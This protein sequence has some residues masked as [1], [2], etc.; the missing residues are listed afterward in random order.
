MLI[1]TIGLILGANVFGHL[2]F[3]HTKAIVPSAITIITTFSPYVKTF[4]TSFVES[5][6]LVISS[7][8]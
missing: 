8:Y 1:S 7:N 4:E 3:L 6:E 2:E 5:V